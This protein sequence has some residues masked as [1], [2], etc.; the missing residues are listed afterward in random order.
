M[1]SSAD[2]I[3]VAAK[4]IIAIVAAKHIVIIIVIVVVI[5]IAIIAIVIIVDIIGDSN[6]I[7]IDCHNENSN[8]AK[9]AHC[10]YC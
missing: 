8:T 2:G 5:V 4:H 3:I 7:I 10:G 9:T 1:S 6:T